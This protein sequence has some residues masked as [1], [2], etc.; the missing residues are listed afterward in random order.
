M[1]LWTAMVPAMEVTTV[2]MNCK[3]LAILFQFTLIIH[4]YFLSVVFASA[5]VE[6]QRLWFNRRH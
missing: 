6:P 5:G 2:A 3:T 4:Y 1:Q